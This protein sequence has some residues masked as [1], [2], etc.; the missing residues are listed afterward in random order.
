MHAQEL[1]SQLIYLLDVFVLGIIDPHETIL[2]SYKVA[3]IIPTA[4]SFIPS[5]IVV[6]IYPYFA[7]HKDDK[8]WCLYNYKRLL[9][10]M[11]G[12]NALLSAILIILA[13]FIVRT[14]FGSDYI[15][16]VSAFR[17]LIVGYFFSSTFR[18][19]AGNLL[20]TQRKLIFNLVLCVTT[21]LANVILNFGFIQKWGSIG[22]AIATVLVV[23]VSG[24][25]CMIRLLFVFSSNNTNVTPDS[26]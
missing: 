2:A 14:F 21:S 4:M 9:R 13:P 19:I 22:A 3:T 11:A 7:E 8:K 23:S 12:F 5:S 15:D 1:L 16:T 18:V 20:V 26:L 6:F 24:I 10:G 25:V 17:I